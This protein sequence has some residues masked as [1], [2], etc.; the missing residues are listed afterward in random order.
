MSVP[1]TVAEVLR[2]HVTLEVEGIDRLYLHRQHRDLTH[3][4]GKQS[5]RDWGGV[6]PAGY[7][8]PAVHAGTRRPRCLALILARGLPAQLPLAVTRGQPGNFST[9]KLTCGRWRCGGKPAR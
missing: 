8:R 2:E 7:R 5:G 3:L 4:R 6:L 9:A 1:R